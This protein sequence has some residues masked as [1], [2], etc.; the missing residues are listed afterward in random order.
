M[1]T[2]IALLLRPDRVPNESWLSY[3][4]FVAGENGFSTLGRL[5]KAIGL[6]PSRLVRGDPADVLW[7][8]GIES[9]ERP[10][11][12][13]PDRFRPRRYRPLGFE[14][15][16]YL[17]V[18]P[19]CIRTGLRRTPLAWDSPLSFHCRIHDC[20]LLDACPQCERNI[21]Q[22]RVDW[23]TCKCTYSFGAARTP[24]AP[25]WMQ[26]LSNVL[27]DPVEPS[28]PDL[29]G[30]SPYRDAHT[31]ADLQYMAETLGFGDISSLFSNDWRARLVGAAS[32]HLIPMRC[33]RR[34]E[35]FKLGG[36]DARVIGEAL[37]EAIG[38]TQADLARARE[39]IAL[40]ATDLWPRRWRD[41]AVYLLRH[42]QSAG[43][44]AKWPARAVDP[45]LAMLEEV[46]LPPERRLGYVEPSPWSGPRRRLGPPRPTKHQR[47]RHGLR[48]LPRPP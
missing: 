8:F 27:E 43:W 3:L 28:G 26:V 7:A 37:L 5:S 40:H 46:L 16:P 21:L 29:L 15:Y 31:L 47:A 23:R 22:V 33:G 13:V 42:V 17:K 6:R 35:F 25:A 1:T 9:A 30:R 11:P 32:K 2:R 34:D 38:F 19:E 45:V 36:S 18:C 14:P 44:R 24:E 4:R 48:D 20:T 41:E 39:K 12:Y 10:P